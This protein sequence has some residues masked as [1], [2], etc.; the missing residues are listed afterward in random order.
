LRLDRPYLLTFFRREVSPSPS[1][2]G[3]LTLSARDAGAGG[4]GV[5]AGQEARARP[6][7]GRPRCAAP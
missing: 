1:R 4:P 5:Q 3:R 7:P 6:I 2:G